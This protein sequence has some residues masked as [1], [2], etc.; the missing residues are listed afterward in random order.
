MSGSRRQPGPL[1]PFVDGY[2]GWLVG[3]GYSPSVVV[4]SLVTLEHFGRWLERNALAVRAL[5]LVLIALA[6]ILLIP[7]S[8]VPSVGLVAAYF[9]VPF[10][11][12][13]LLVRLHRIVRPRPLLLADTDG[14]TVGSL[15]RMGWGEVEEMGPCA[16][17]GVFGALGVLPTEAVAERQNPARRSLMRMS[18]STSR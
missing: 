1:G 4:R 12:L 3:R 14:L 2:R 16:I 18:T 10:F 8:E 9:G 6:L 15:G 5:L 17:Y 11:G 13:G 7:T